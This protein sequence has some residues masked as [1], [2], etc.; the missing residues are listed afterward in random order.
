MITLLALLAVLPFMVLASLPTWP[1]STKWTYMPSAT[2]SA[3][4]VSLL[5]L[6]VAGGL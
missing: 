5:L 4:T 3:V 2:L 1:Y 6:I